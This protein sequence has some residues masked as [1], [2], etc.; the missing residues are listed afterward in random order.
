MSCPCN[1]NWG[2]GSIWRDKKYDH[3]QCVTY[4]YNSDKDENEID[5]FNLLLKISIKF[6]TLYSFINNNNIS[7]DMI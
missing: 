6:N 3:T 7:E 4:E 5:F 2:Y 1:K